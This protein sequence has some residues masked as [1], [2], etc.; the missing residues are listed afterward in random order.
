MQAVS[1]SSAGLIPPLDWHSRYPSQRERHEFLINNAE[2]SD[3]KFLVGENK[4]LVLG[5]K[6]LLSTGSP[7]FHSMFNGELS[8]RSNEIDI[9][10]LDKDSFINLMR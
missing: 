5:H 9:P 8:E 7:V 1:S 10:D 6:F 2:M 4:D 3:I